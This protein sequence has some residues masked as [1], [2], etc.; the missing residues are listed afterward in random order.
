MEHNNIEIKESTLK[1]KSN[2]VLFNLAL[3]KEKPKYLDINECIHLNEVKID[4]IFTN[5]QVTSFN[6][7]ELSQ[8]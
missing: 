5:M 4:I 6:L 7:D 2:E 3:K 8:F 1:G